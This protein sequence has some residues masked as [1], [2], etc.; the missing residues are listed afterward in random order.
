MIDNTVKM[1]YDSNAKIFIEKL[2][3]NGYWV[4]I[5]NCKTTRERMD[6]YV[7]VYF[8]KDEEQCDYVKLDE[9]SEFE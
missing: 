5:G 2:L 9:E 4:K 3:Q 1:Q 7:M 6:N 8:E